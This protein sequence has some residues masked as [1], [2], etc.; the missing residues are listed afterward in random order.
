MVCPPDNRQ[1]RPRDPCRRHRLDFGMDRV[2]VIRASHEDAAEADRAALR[3]LTP[4]QRVDRALDLIA[5][6][7]EA[8]G[9]AGQGFARIARIVPFERR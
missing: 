7:R 4:Q 2:V 1:D 6:H 8:L 9:E 5:R 3:M